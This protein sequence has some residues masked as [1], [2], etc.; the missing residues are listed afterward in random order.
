MSSLS[1]MFRKKADAISAMPNASPKSMPR[2]ISGH[3]IPSHISR[4]IMWLWP[5]AP[6]LKMKL[7][8]VGSSSLFPARSPSRHARAP[9]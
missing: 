7:D 3:N 4:D 8:T 1:A 2:V 6:A 5:N 9:K